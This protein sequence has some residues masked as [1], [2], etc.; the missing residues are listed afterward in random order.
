MSHMNQLRRDA[1]TRRV[2]L[3]HHFLP[4]RERR[5]AMEAGHIRLIERG[6]TADPGR[7]CDDETAATLRAAAI[8]AGDLGGRRV[9][10]PPARN[11]SQATSQWTLPGDQ[12]IPASLAAPIR[13]RRR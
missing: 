8:V 10:P 3:V 13:S 12:I 11:C 4:T 9:A 1:P 2:N 6:R 5:F 7:F